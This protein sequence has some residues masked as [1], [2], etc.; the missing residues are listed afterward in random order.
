MDRR[1]QITRFL[2]PEQ[3]GIEIGPY[4]RPLMPKKGGN[5]CL[6]LDVFDGKTLR[7]KA[8]ADPNIPRELIND[9]EDVDLIGS[10]TE[11][12]ELAS[13]YPAASF[14]YVI[15]SHNLEHLP[16]P[17]RFLQGCQKILKPG[18]VVSMAVPD[19]R[20]CFD[21]FR[22]HSTTADWLEAYFSKSKRPSPAQVFTQNS[23]HSRY[24]RGEHLLLGF[25]LDEDPS[26]V[27]PLQ[28]VEE[29]FKRWTDFN[30]NPDET[31]HDVHCWA[32][33]PAS[34]ELILTDLK[35]LGVLHLDVQQISGAYENE[36][37]VRLQNPQK[38]G[39]PGISRDNFYQK[40]REL[41]HKAA[42]ES[43]ENSNR[44]YQLRRQPPER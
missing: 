36:F 35:Y 32:F 3:Q 43:S 42:D 12:A 1:A 44:V 17:I 5:H 13:K 37:F 10:S 21:Y 31:Y 41:L 29:A 15:S 6:V 4:F 30:A 26:N 8:A 11:I 33:T 20:V 24:R 34:M 14:D 25:N 23:L 38:P 19:R 40:R 9:I 28:T 39:A 16:D 27:I 22:P 18:G 7:E 2:T